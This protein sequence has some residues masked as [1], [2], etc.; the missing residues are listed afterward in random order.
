MK[1]KLGYMVLL[2]KM[3]PDECLKHVIEA[4]KVGM[5]MIWVDDHFFPF[6]PMTE[7]GFA[8]CFMAS[9]LQA[10]KKI[11]FATGVTA[12]I[13]RYNPAI[14]AQAFAT[15]NC[16]YPG[17]VNLGVGTGEDLNEIPLLC[18]TWPKPA[19]RLEMLADVV[20]IIK[21]LWTSDKAMSRNGNYCM[22]DVKLHTKP[23]TKIPIYFSGI[24]PKASKLAGIKGDHLITLVTNPKVLKEVVFPNFEAGAREAGKDPN[25]ME[26]AIVMNFT[27]DPSK[28]TEKG[29]AVMQQTEFEAR[30]TVLHEPEDFVTYIDELVDLGFTHIVLNDISPNNGPALEALKVATAHFK[31]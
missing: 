27:Y 8:W 26:R 12:P 10:T 29:H 31:K 1:T 22:K 16:M 25:K 30:F 13:M 14:V 21:E 24:G 2:E 11:P 23:K 18:V 9:A 4:E 7:S 15:M 20:D 17:R 6:P 3:K 19:K 5:D 28:S